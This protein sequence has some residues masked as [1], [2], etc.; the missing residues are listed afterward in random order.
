MLAVRA[1]GSIFRTSDEGDCENKIGGSCLLEIKKGGRG[2]NPRWLFEAEFIPLVQG[3]KGPR[4][5]Y[6]FVPFYT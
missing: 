4:N 2:G 3:G 1:V 6:D 5:R